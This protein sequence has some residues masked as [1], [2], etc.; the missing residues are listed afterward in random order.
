[1]GG[2]GLRDAFPA[3]EPGHDEVAGIAAVDVE[4]ARQRCP[5]AVA[6]GLHDEALAIPVAA[7]DL[8]GLAVD[9]VMAAVE[10]DGMRGLMGLAKLGLERVDPSR[11]L[12]PGDDR[13]GSSRSAV[14]E[15]MAAKIAKGCDTLTPQIST[16]R[17]AAP[18]R[19]TSANRCGRRWTDWDARAPTVAI[20]LQLPEISSSSASRSTS[21]RWPAAASNKS[22]QLIGGK[23]TSVSSRCGDS[24]A[25][26]T[27]CQRMVPDSDQKIGFAK[28]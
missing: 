16:S 18:S 20:W 5:P 15:D 19:R 22:C 21:A 23:R 17:A 3:G 13:L 8:P 14:S 4:H 9:N 11:C 26:G 12:R 25:S 2:D 7:G 24:G 27:G 1:M 6:A 28:D 10:A